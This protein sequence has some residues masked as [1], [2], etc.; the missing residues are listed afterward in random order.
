MNYG[1]QNEMLFF[2]YCKIDE[3]TKEN[4]EKHQLYFKC[5]IEFNDPF[6]SK[7][8]YMY[9]GTRK[10]WD[11]FFR[12]KRQINNLT[13]WIKKGIV[14]CDRNSN[15]CLDPNSEN[16]REYFSHNLNDLDERNPIRICC[17]SK[18]ATN[19]LMW[20]HYA[21]DHKGICLRFRS[22]L[23]ESEYCLNLESPV[24][25]FVE[26]KY[27]KEMPSPVNV[28]KLDYEK[29]AMFPFTKHSD[30]RYEKEWRLLSWKGDI[31]ENNTINYK[32]EDLEGVVFGSKAL[33]K[34]EEDNKQKEK[35]H[36]IIDIIDRCYI[37]EG[38]DV[39]FYKAKEIPGKYE[40]K[41][42]KL[43]PQLLR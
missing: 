13:D 35:I 28:L 9:R 23:K 10:E 21:N 8:N 11:E 40:V 31:K 20:S 30:W 27:T 16:F 15:Y 5:P 38:I 18:T 7:I 22:K 37:K 36:E 1:K 43:D 14:T 25:P 26:V 33:E 34:I 41:I 6:D 32:K 19:I 3:Y 42:E 29:L 17:F 4:L 24:I 12:K 2:K 39:N